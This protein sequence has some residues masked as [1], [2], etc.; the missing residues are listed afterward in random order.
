MI[1][2]IVAI[3]KLFFFLFY[4]FVDFRIDFSCHW[5]IA[6]YFNSKQANPFCRK[7]GSMRSLAR[8]MNPYNKSHP[9]IN[10]VRRISANGTRRILPFSGYPAR[11]VEMKEILLPCLVVGT[12]FIIKNKKVCQCFT[13]THQL[14]KFFSV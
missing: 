5:P 11:V 14:P 9:F 1:L 10:N 7:Y 13:N 6:Q 8:Q 3:F 12:V 4:D 2:T